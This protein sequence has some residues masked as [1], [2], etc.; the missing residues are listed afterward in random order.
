MKKRIFYT[1]FYL[2]FLFVAGCA[3]NDNC[4]DFDCFTPPASFVFDLIDKESGENIFRSGSYTPEQVEVW[5]RTDDEQVAFGYVI[6]DQLY[7]ISIQSIGWKTE[8]VEYEILLDG[9]VILGLYVDVERVTE[10][11]CNFTKYN[12]IR[13]DT[14]EY[15]FDETIGIYK[16]YLD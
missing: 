7:W 4:T 11:C 16:I 5:N 6:E 10:N 15:E 2:S 12:E 3:D 13:V 14:E 9:E 1:L 8:K